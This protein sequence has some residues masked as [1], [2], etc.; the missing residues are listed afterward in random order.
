MLPGLMAMMMAL[1]R[2]KR[3]KMMIFISPGKGDSVKEPDI[4]WAKGKNTLQIYDAILWSEI[5][6]A[7]NT[8]GFPSITPEQPLMTCNSQYED[9]P[10]GFCEIIAWM[11]DE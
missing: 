2:L 10:S 6:A 8:L 5:R 11:T 4:I 1:P 3:L 7:A 9:G